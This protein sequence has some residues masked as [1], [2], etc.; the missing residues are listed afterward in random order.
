MNRPGMLVLE[1]LN[2][3]NI[4]MFC[5]SRHGRTHLTTLR[6]STLYTK[7]FVWNQA[8]VECMGNVYTIKYNRSMYIRTLVTK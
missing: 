6:T 7:E 1:V 2:L 3:Y 8:R 5:A 4:S